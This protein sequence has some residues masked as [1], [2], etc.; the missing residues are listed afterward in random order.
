[1]TKKIV[2][3]TW[4]TKGVFFLNRSKTEALKGNEAK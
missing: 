4:Q 2:I 1:M 3:K